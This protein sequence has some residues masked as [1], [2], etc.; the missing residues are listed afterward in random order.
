MLLRSAQRQRRRWRCC[1]PRPP[2]RRQTIQGRAPIGT[3][4]CAGCGRP[5]SAAAAAA[6]ALTLRRRMTPAP[7]LGRRPMCGQRDTHRPLQAARSGQSCGTRWRARRW[8]TVRGYAAPRTHRYASRCRHSSR[9]GTLRLRSPAPRSPRAVTVARAERCARRRCRPRHAHA[10]SPPPSPQP[11]L[12]TR[13]A[14]HPPS[15]LP[16]L[17]LRVPRRAPRLRG[18][19]R[20]PTTPAGCP[21][22]PHTPSPSRPPSLPHEHQEGTS[23]RAALGA[24]RQ[25]PSQRPGCCSHST[26]RTA[27]SGAPTTTRRLCHPR[28]SG[29][30]P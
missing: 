26:G 27:G 1:S 22:L 16:P 20:Q 6:S 5:R 15:A 11:P 17:H 24:H 28:E 7:T 13:H 9:R 14:H 4:G 29:G 23:R 8:G 10:P 25:R 18:P 21:R 3:P 12:R 19:R 2:T 30:S